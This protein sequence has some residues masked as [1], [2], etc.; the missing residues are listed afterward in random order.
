MKKFL[1]VSHAR[2]GSLWTAMALRAVGFDVG[3]ESGS[4]NIPNYG[5]DGDV[6]WLFKVNDNEGFEDKISW[7]VY[8][9]RTYQ[10]VVHQVRHP[11]KVIASQLIEGLHTYHWMMVLEGYPKPTEIKWWNYTNLLFYVM[12]NWYY[13]NLRCE[14]VSSW[15]FK[16]EDANTTFPTICKQLGLEERKTPE[17]DATIHR[18]SDELRKNY[19]DITWDD[20][21]KC[22][23]DLYLKIIDMSK[24]YG[25]DVP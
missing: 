5:I 15:R 12:W 22:D 21:K 25:Y 17:L 13:W 2:S 10:T 14:R 4:L 18:R 23:N 9:V 16:I 19:H 8:D 7:H 6:S 20:L 1:V 11:L 24:K 3:H